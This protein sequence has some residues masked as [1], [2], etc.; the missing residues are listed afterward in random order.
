MGNIRRGENKRESWWVTNNTSETI[1]IGDLLLVPAIKPGKRVDL[2][3]YYSREKISHSTVLIS[4]VK[5]GI[6]SLSKDKNFTNEFPG[7]ITAA[8]IDEALIPAEE[9]EVLKESEANDIYLRL[10]GN[11][12]NQNIG[13]NNFGI[14]EVGFIDFDLNVT[15]AHQEGRLKW[16][17]NDKTLQIDTEQNDVQLQIGQ[18]MYVRIVNKTGSQINNGEVVYIDGAQGNRPTAT[19]A[20]ADSKTTSMGT[21]GFATHN[22]PDSQNGYIT[23]FGLVRD[24]DTSSFSEGDMLYLS[25]TTAGAFTTTTPIAPD[26]AVTLGIVIT[27]DANNGIIFARIN[28]GHELDELHDV[29]I[30][31]ITNNNIMQYNSNLNVWENKNQLDLG[32]N[33]EASIFFDG[34]DLNITLND[35]SQTGDINLTDDVNISGI[36]KT[37]SGKIINR[38][39]VTTTP[40]AIKASD[41]HLSITTSSVAITLNLPVIV[42]GT[43]YHIKDQDEQSSARNITVNPNGS[44]TIENASSLTIKVNG[45]AITIVGNS[46]TNNW[47]IQ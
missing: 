12:A 45:A 8:T 15:A 32:E 14:Q 11:N 18:E 46:T 36:L 4:L 3:H 26:H 31:N 25:S 10:S 37:L 20:K 27:V 16:N 30:S 9:N 22:I 21:L 23:S 7:E 29:L 47:E 35:P 13:I 43:I 42:D 19:L 6:V 34:T 40:Y 39:S 5:A 41:H 1:T 33:S 2:L 44:D 28:N 17:D 24:L 38:T